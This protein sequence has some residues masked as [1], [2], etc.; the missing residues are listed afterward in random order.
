MGAT[1]KRAGPWNLSGS[2]RCS[3]SWPRSAHLPATSLSGGQQQ[4]V[5]IGRALMSNPKV[6]LCDELSPRPGADRDPRD[7]RRACRRSAPKA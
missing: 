5:A 1:A 7:L 3:R 6:L 4:M 2:M